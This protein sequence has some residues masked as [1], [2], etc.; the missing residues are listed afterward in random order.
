MSFEE[1]EK[2]V[3][4]WLRKNPKFRLILSDDSEKRFYFEM[5]KS[6]S[7]SQQFY[8]NFPASSN[9]TLGIATEGDCDDFLKEAKKL[10]LTKPNLSV[11]ELLSCVG[12]SELSS[13]FP[14]SSKKS[15]K[16]AD[17][18]EDDLEEEE[19][20]DFGNDYE[21]NEESDGEY[22]ALTAK[23]DSKMAAAVL[24]QE[25]FNRYASTGTNMA[26]KRLFSDMKAFQASEGKFGVLGAPRDDNLYIWDVK[27]TDFDPASPLAKD[28]DTYAKKFNKEPAVLMEMTFQNDY[29][30][31]PPFVRVVCPR[32]K[33]LT[34]HVTIGGSIC[35]QMLTRS[36]WSPSNDIESILIQ[37]R[38]E[39]VSDPN[40][41]LDLQN[42]KSYTEAE[43]KDAFKRMVDRYKWN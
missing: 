30:M 2:A 12:S 7:S 19:D 4:E 13:G 15:G 8:V 14:Q 36:G 42:D 22:S 41:H 11:E 32:F 31:T 17:D 43:A 10:C 21:Y 18:V 35:M 39:I 3:N 5:A 25:E 34:G 16:D 24:E 23:A 26:T 29:P 27:L 33:F 37:I 20:D 6:S 9:G 1:A 28:L 40:V 38:C